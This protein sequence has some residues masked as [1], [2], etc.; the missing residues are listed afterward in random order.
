MSK[1]GKRVFAAFVLIIA[2]F[3]LFMKKQM[4]IMGFQHLDLKKSLNTMKKQ[5]REIINFQGLPLQTESPL[6]IFNHRL[7][8]A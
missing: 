3:L 4:S 7:E 8:K 6:T 5:K 1:K 2:I